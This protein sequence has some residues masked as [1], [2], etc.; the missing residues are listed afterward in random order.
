MDLPPDVVIRPVD[1]TDPGDLEDAYAVARACEMADVGWS[2][3]TRESVAAQL[4]GPLAWREQHR[5]AYL[6]S[7]LLYTS[8][9][10]DE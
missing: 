10:A 2:D 7:C 3:A 1:A 5:L 8:D 6:G 9:A 4:T